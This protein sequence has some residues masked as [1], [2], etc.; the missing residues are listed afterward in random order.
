MDTLS[1]AAGNSTDPTTAL[2]AS[3]SVKSVLVLAFAFTLSIALRRASAA[4]RHTLWL[5]SLLAL[6]GLPLLSLS[7]P[8]FT[9][10]ILPAA[11]PSSSA[12]HSAIA[13][14]RDPE[15]RE[16]GRLSSASPFPPIVTGDVT[17]PSISRAAPMTA[18]HAKT[19]DSAQN[20]APALARQR[21]SPSAPWLLLIW[22]A[23]VCLMLARTLLGFAGARRLVQRCDVILGGATWERVQ[24]AR[25][26]LSVARRVVLRVGSTDRTLSVPMTCGVLH[27]TI[28]LPRNASEWPEERLRAAILH[29]TA[30]IRRRDWLTMALTQFVCALYWWNPLVWVAAQKLRLESEQACDDLVLGAGV[31]AADYASHLL[32]VARGLTASR[33]P[34]A[35][36]AMAQPREI[37]RRLESILA[38]HRDRRGATRGGFA[39]AGVLLA[40][41]GSLAAIHLAA[42]IHAISQE[43]PSRLSADASP[44]A[45]QLKLVQT[46]KTDDKV[47]CIAFTPDSKRILAG[48]WSTLW[49]DFQTKYS[50]EG[51]I[52]FW[53]AETGKQLSKRR[54]PAPLISVAYSP[55]GRLLATGYAGGDLRI[56]DSAT[57]RTLRQTHLPSDGIE[58]LQF[59]PDGLTLACGTF[60]S[61]ECSSGPGPLYLVDPSTGRQRD[62]GYH[63]VFRKIPRRWDR[64]WFAVG[65]GRLVTWSNGV[66]LWSPAWG[67]PTIH[68]RQYLAR[69]CAVQGNRVAILEDS[70]IHLWD[71]RARREVGAV[72]VGDLGNAG[73]PHLAF[74]PDGRYLAY[75]GSGAIKVWRVSGS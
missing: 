15:A 1:W 54:L 65:N 61:G 70:E 28:L 52:A 58:V 57:G 48:S 75:G 40:G 38:E 22:I 50:H 32:D 16:S 4:S 37:A 30:H 42:R 55:D 33:Q 6:A 7:V 27:P 8:K 60:Q 41:S 59:S 13:A 66:S 67:Q 64:Q 69:I 14:Q 46:L 63:G 51:V 71:I 5:A 56:S 25:R 73:Y 10:P 3:V 44:G 9:L 18:A 43:S 20:A 62:K 2:W 17:P 31:P 19:K 68:L 45:V 29:E 24:D 26:R 74:S 23:G 49:D 36:V 72:S 39:L 21:T 12:R 53:S 35:A 47:N 11:A 34:L